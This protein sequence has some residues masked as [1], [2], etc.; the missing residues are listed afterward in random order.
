MDAVEFLKTVNRLCKKN[1]SC[2]ECPIFCKKG[3]CMLRRTV[4]L[5][6]A[7]DASVESSIDEMI[8]IVE[9]WAKDHPVKTRQSEFL[10][11][12][13]NAKFPNAKTD[14]GVII[15]CPRGFLPKGEAEAYCEKHDECI[16]CCKD[17]WLTEVT[18]ND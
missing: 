5:C 12:F 16:E 8:S 10:K 2:E 9:Q 17:Y 11:M 15:F 4:M 7:S 1:Q 6:D 13:P 3:M 18:D 14:G